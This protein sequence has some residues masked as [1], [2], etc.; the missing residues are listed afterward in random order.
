MHHGTF[1]YFSFWRRTLITDLFRTQ[2][3]F[4]SEWQALNASHCNTGQ[5]HMHFDRPY[6]LHDFSAGMVAFHLLQRRRFCF[7]PVV[8]QPGHV[9]WPEVI[10]ESSGLLLQLPEGAFDPESETVKPDHGQGGQFE[11]GSCQNTLCSIIFHKDKAEFL[12]RISSAQS[13]RYLCPV[14]GS[15]YLPVTSY[16]RTVQHIR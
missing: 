9:F 4:H 11:T 6:C 13:K 2:F 16:S 8:I 7:L 15:F 10:T 1:W 14:S 3:S 5:G 12:I